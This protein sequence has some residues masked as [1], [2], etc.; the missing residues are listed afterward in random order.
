MVSFKTALLSVCALG[1]IVILEFLFRQP[2]FDYSLVFIP[3]L[4]SDAS[5]EKVKGWEMYSD[6][7]Y[8]VV[9]SH[10]AVFIA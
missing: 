5:D 7:I 1:I 6:S 2:L 3:R 9:D 10:L 4:Q 8:L